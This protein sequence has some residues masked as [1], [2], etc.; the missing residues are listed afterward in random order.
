MVPGLTHA[1][2]PRVAVGIVAYN[3]GADLPGCF[4]A[5]AAQ[6]YPALEI[7]VLDNASADDG[8]AWLAAHQPHVPLLRNPRNEGFARGH[9]RLLAADPLGPT[10]YYMPLNPDVRLAPDYVARLLARLEATGAGWGTGKLL[11]AQ[12]G[13]SI[14]SVGHALR[15]DGYAFNIGHGLPDAGQFEQAREIFGAP[16]AAPLVRQSLIEALGGELFDPTMFLYHEDVDFDWRARRRG[17]RCWYEPLAVATHRGSQP[18]GRLRTQA[19][20][21]RYLSVLKNAEPA[22]LL[23]F[24]LPLMAAHCAGRLAL[25]PREGWS[26]VRQLLRHG[27]AAWAKRRPAALPRAALEGWFRWGASQPTGQPTTWRQRWR[28]FRTLAARAG[29][30]PSGCD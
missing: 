26:L 16:G 14:Y 3:S 5:L 29:G 10:D 18:G 25:T 2:R 28:A 30:A 6:T 11:L 15:R 1:R 8:V 21:N 12:S 13:R 27:P 24:N 4:A 20:G 7:R 17:W 22:D 9:N 19:L 23:C